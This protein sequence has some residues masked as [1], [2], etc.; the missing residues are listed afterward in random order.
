V[1]IEISGGVKSEISLDVVEQKVVCIQVHL[2]I[3]RRKSADEG[4]LLPG[5]VDKSEGFVAESTVL[6]ISFCLASKY[7]SCGKFD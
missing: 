3:E 2:M 7:F 6:Q 1:V 4:I 5:D